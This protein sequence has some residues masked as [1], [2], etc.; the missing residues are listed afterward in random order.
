VR[1]DDKPKDEPKSPKEKFEAL[2]KEFGEQ[3]QQAIQEYQKAK[4][5]DKQAALQKY[6]GLGKEF[7]PKFY[8]LAEDNAK[9]P[10]A[11][12]ALFWVLMYG[13]DTPAF[14]K[15]AEK[16]AA[17]AADMP[18]ADLVKR[19][20]NIRGNFPVLLTAARKRAEKE[21]K[22]AL[23]G[24]LLAWVAM[25]GGGTADGT[26]SAERL[27]EKYPDHKAIE[28]LCM[29]LSREGS[30]GAAATLKK[31]LEK[32]TKPAV[33]AAAALALG[34]SLSSQVDQLGDD[35]PKADKV[36]A[37]AEQYFVRVVDELAKDNAAVKSQAERELKALRTLRVGK[38]A[39]EIKAGD[40][41]E[42][43]F[44]LTDYRGKVVLLDFWGNW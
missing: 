2:R 29:F 8:Q 9:D 34:R 42:K 23:A 3:Q 39:P 19:L 22:D 32:S 16:V 36:A 44:K 31:V 1:A 20:N 26:K 43:E 35:L 7:A 12:E 6:R 33:Q 37:E 14:E 10:A 11:V 27:I 24:D 38:E 21:E 25:T 18:L 30:P 13:D 5:A 15:A 28:Q 41:D 4:G 17:L 40:L